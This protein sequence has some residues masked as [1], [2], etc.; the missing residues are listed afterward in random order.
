MSI[1]DPPV[2]DLHQSERDG[3][4]LLSLSGDLDARVTPLLRESLVE[5]I[6]TRSGVIVV[7]LRNV[8][9]IDSVALGTL[10]G[11]LKRS[12]ERGATLRFVVSTNQIHKVLTITGLNR[13]FDVYETVDAA[14]QGRQ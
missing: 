6:E 5:A 12:N 3:A 2:L 14:L 8:V 11:A 10:V 13:V 9:Y 7:D 4:V 1:Q